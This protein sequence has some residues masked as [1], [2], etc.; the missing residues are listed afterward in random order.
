MTICIYSLGSLYKD[1]G[2]VRRY[3]MLLNENK[4][5]IGGKDSDYNLIKNCDYF[6]PYKSKKLFGDNGLVFE[7]IYKRIDEP[8]KIDT[9]E[10]WNIEFNNGNNYYDTIEGS[11]IN[12]LNE[13]KKLLENNSYDIVW[14]VKKIKT[15]TLLKGD[16]KFLVNRRLSKIS[17]SNP[18]YNSL[19]KLLK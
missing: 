13:Y 19:I 3:D 18:Y 11:P 4:M 6:M 12:G 9:I 2:I 15:I 5:V 1:W 16:Y 17:E 7:N 10:K 14:H 8:I